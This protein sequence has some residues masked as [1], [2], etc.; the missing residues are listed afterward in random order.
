MGW[1]SFIEEN[2][3]F[4][5]YVHCDP[6][7]GNVLIR[8]NPNTWNNRLEVVLIDHGLYKELDDETRLDYAQLWKAIVTRDE[9][10][11][12]QKAEK[13]GIPKFQLFAL[14]LTYRT[15]DLYATFEKMLTLSRGDVGIMR[16]LTESELERGKH[17]VAQHW[18]N[19]INLLS[20]I[21]DQILLLLKCKYDC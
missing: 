13:L 9:K 2:I 16:N 18:V 15:W 7:P 11:G 5:S 12:T 6:H 4:V 3:N 1:H 19:I 8:R 17:W 20:T 14:M 10:L 21:P